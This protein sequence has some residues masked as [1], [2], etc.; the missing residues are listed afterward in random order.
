[1]FV[2]SFR[3]M[4]RENN[5]SVEGLRL[6]FDFLEEIS[7]DYDLDVI[8]LCCDYSED[9]EDEIRSNYSIDEDTS[10]EDYLND[11]TSVVGKTSCGNFVY[12]SF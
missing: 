5:F 1:M 6:L 8:A 11:N 12:A 2:D 3:D 7:P 10:V 4:N 9:T